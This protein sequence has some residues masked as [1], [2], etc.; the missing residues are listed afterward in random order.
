MKK[1]EHESSSTRN[2]ELVDSYEISPYSFARE[3]GIDLQKLVTGVLVCVLGF[4]FLGVSI[5]YQEEKFIRDKTFNYYC[6]T[7][8]CLVIGASLI[9]KA[10]YDRYRLLGNFV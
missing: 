4:V 10:Y 1:V 3:Q 5:Q 6:A 9:Y 2:V 7:V 8:V